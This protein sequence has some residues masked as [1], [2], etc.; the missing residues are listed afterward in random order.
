MVSEN[1]DAQGPAEA[2]LINGVVDDGCALDTC[3]GPST[4]L[5]RSACRKCVCGSNIASC[6]CR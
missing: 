4:R 3:A 5:G 6:P 2:G 1:F